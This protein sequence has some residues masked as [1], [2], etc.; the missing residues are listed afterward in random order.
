MDGKFANEERIG[1]LSYWRDILLIAAVIISCLYFARSLLIPLAAAI[2]LFVLLTALADRIIRFRFGNFGIPI[3][4]AYVV[5]IILVLFGMLSVLWILTQQDAAVFAAFPKYEARFAI[6]ISG[7]GDFIGEDNTRFIISTL[8]SLDF[9]GWAL[10]ALGSATSVLKMLFLIVLFLPFML[11]ERVQMRAKVKLAAVSP[12]VG[13]QILNV[14]ND[15]SHSLQR[16]IGVK[17]L[18]SLLTGAFSYAVMKPLGVDFAETWAIMTFLLNF[19]PSIGSIISV[20]MPA[21]VAIVQFDSITPF[22]IIVFGCGGIQFLIGNVLEPALM[23]KSLNLSP[24][25]VIFSLTF[26][27]TI[28]GVMGALLSVPITVCIMLLLSHVPRV[29]WIAILMSGNGTFPTSADQSHPEEHP[30]V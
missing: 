22:L 18:V 3:W 10:G 4:L 15:A 30:L 2:F 9:R 11:A 19:I 5:S 16:Y 12:E 13:T 14:M 28:W 21:I 6:W 24:L 25:M 26:W 20:V 27:G 17:T 1:G 8:Q 29:R 7:F 23:G